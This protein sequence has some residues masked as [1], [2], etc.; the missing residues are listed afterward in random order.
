MSDEPVFRD[1]LPLGEPARSAVGTSPGVPEG[2]VEGSE[3]C[4]V[5]RS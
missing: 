2:G 1:P 4:L 5:D 3:R